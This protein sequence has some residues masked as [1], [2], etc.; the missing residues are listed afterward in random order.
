MS[1]PLHREILV[2]LSY[3][4]PDPVGLAE[5]LIAE[6]EIPY[7]AVGVDALTGAAE[8]RLNYLEDTYNKI[9]VWLASQNADYEIDVL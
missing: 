5:K 1:S 2:F 7:I 3:A 6:L 4:N 8:I 9:D